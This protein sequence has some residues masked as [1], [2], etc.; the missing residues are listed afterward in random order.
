MKDNTK[1]SIKVGITLAVITCICLSIVF[2]VS[3]FTKNEITKAQIS[4]QNARFAN[5]LPPNSFNNNP[6]EECYI[7]NQ[8][9]Q[10]DQKIYIARKNNKITGYVITYDIFGGYS[11]PFVMVA[12]VKDDFSI[13]Y[14]DIVKFNETPGLGDKVFR[15]K[16]N[17]LDSFFNTSLEKNNFEVKKYGGDFDYYT[18]ATVTPR[19]IVRSTG[20]MLRKLP[21][22]SVESLPKCPKE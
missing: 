19:A 4:E 9:S 15:S 2:W 21:G 1:H 17:F 14:V 11:T 6:S 12:G 22:F 18:G 8:F 20:Q 7:T 5:L 3:N 16:G 13:H 10:Y